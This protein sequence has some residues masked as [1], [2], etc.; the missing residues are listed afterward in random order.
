MSNAD[1]SPPSPSWSST[2][3]L[4]IG[5]TFVAIFTALLVYFRTIIG[6]LLLAVILA[7]ALHP[8]TARI[9][10]VTNLNWRWSVNLIY[11]VLVIIVLGL[12]TASGFAI[13]QQLQSLIS[14]VNNFTRTLPELVAQISQQTYT[15]GP[16]EFSLK[17]YDLQSLTNQVLG[18]LQPLLGRVGTLVGTFATG[19]FSTLG[20]GFFVLLISYFLLA[21]SGKVSSDLIRI[22]IPGYSTDIRRLGNELVTIWNVF[23]RGQ[24]VMFLLATIIYTILMTGLGLRYSLAIAILAGI[25]RFI[26]YIGPLV[27]WIVTA[28]VAL[29]QGQ[30]YFGLQA[31][32]YAALVLITALIIDQILDNVVNPRFMGHR[33]GVHPAAV[34]V[35]ALVAANLIGLVGVVLAAPVLASMVLLGRY[36]S[37]KMLDLDPWPATT[38]PVKPMEY[39]WVRLIHRLRA[40]LRMATRRA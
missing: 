3:K 19:A 1:P 9:N 24:L 5:L 11:L 17:Q 30:N 20:W 23:L 16:F 7:Y 27:V 15:F 18:T 2:T 31:W 13:V 25:A 38:Q 40:W 35:A 21:E 37:R 26:P 10:R 22:D 6:P 34:L 32:Q 4:V 8:L 29:L 39:P 14:V 33:L 28:L 12:L 36:F